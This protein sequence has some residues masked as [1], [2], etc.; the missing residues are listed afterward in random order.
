LQNNQA[1]VTIYVLL[2]FSSNVITTTIPSFT[3]I[4]HKNKNQ[5]ILFLFLDKILFTEQPLYISCRHK[6][7]SSFLK[8]KDNNA[9]QKI[10]PE[11]RK[12]NFT[13]KKL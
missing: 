4:F 7:F 10:F 1:V 13:K 6:F 2:N 9:E 8:K 12:I 3:T 11:K 5:L